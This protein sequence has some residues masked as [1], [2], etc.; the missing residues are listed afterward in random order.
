MC[1]L[2]NLLESAIFRILSKN[3]LEKIKSPKASKEL[4]LLRRRG[5]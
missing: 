3:V 4:P 5:I 2:I 1:N